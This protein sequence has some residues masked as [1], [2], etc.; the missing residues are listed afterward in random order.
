MSIIGTSRFNNLQ[1]RLSNILGNGTGDRGYGQALA[2]TAAIPGDIVLASDINKLYSDMLK[3][4]VHQ[5]GTTPTQIAE[6]DADLN[7]IA[8]EISNQVNNLGDLI[9][10]VDGSKKGIIA[11]ETLMTSLE[12]NRFSMDP[13]QAAEQVVVS[14]ARSRVWDSAIVHEF[15]ATFNNADHRRHFF[16]SGGEIRIKPSNT[17]PTSPKGSAWQIFLNNVGTIIFN[18]NGT[19]SSGIGIGT[20][21]GN[22]GLGSN[23]LKIFEAVSPGGINE[24]VNTAGNYYK[25]EARQVSSRQ[26]Q[27]R[28]TMDDVVADQITSPTQNINV[29][30]SGR[31]NAKSPG[32]VIQGYQISLVIDT[33]GSMTA[34]N[35]NKTRLQW[36]KEAANALIDSLIPPGN[37][38]NVQISIVTFSSVATVRSQFTTNVA[39]LKST[40]N[41]LTA[42]G[43]TSIHAGIDAAFNLFNYTQTGP[44]LVQNGSFEN[45]TGLLKTTFGFRAF[46]SLA[47]GWTTFE[48]TGPRSEID[49]HGDNRGGIVPVGKYWIDLAASPGDIR[50]GQSIPNLIN[51][52]KYT[53]RFKAARSEQDRFRVYWNGQIIANNILPPTQLTDYEFIVTAGSGNGQ[54]RFEFENINAGNSNIGVAIDDVRFFRIGQNINRQIIVFGDGIPVPSSGIQLSKDS[55]VRAVNGIVDSV[56]TIAIPGANVPL[57]QELAQLGN[58]IFSNFTS[59]QSLVNLINDLTTGSV[60]YVNIG[61]LDLIA[62]DG[63]QYNNVNFDLI[64]NFQFPVNWQLQEGNNIFRARATIASTGAIVN[65]TLNI[66][67][68]IPGAPIPAPPPAQTTSEI[69]WTN[70]NNN[71]QVQLPISVFVVSGLVKNDVSIYKASGTNLVID[72][73]TITNNK[74]LAE[75][76]EPAPVF[77]LIASS[78]SVV[79][80]NSFEVTLSTA[81]VN[82]GTVVPYTITGVTS[83]QISGMPLTGSF[84]INSGNATIQI[85]TVDD[86]ILNPPKTFTLAL[87]QDPSKFVNVIIEDSLATVSLPGEFTVD[88]TRGNVL[89]S[90]GQTIIE[91]WDISEIVAL[92]LLLWTAAE[93]VDII[94]DWGDGSIITY[95]NVIFNR[96]SH[97]Y[98]QNGIYTIKY[99]VLYTPR[100][101]GS[102]IPAA[103]TKKTFAG[104]R[105]ANG[106][107][108]NQLITGVTSFGNNIGLEKIKLANAF[109]L[110]SVPSVIPTTVY[111]IEG[112]FSFAENVIT[113]L[114]PGVYQANISPNYNIDGISQWNVSQVGDFTGLFL[115]NA[116]VNPAIENW[117][118]SNAVFLSRMFEG[119][120]SFDR[121]LNNWDTS[122]VTMMERMFE[123]AS[124]FNSPIAN[125][126]TS[127]VFSMAGMFKNASSF[128]S[129][130]A[131][132]PSQDYWNTINVT[133]MSSIFE[134]ASAFNQNIGNWNTAKVQ[135]MS[136]MFF[137][138]SSFNQNIGAWDTSSV[139][140]MAGMFRNALTFDQP[141]GNWDTS[142][143]INMNS[144]FSGS[145]VFDQNIGSWN[146]S[147]VANMGFMFN[148]A[149]EFNQPIN[150]WDTSKV[151]SMF[152]M[153]TSA[154]TFNQNIGGWDTSKVTDMTRMFQNAAAFNQDIG[155]WD[156][157]A[158]P[159]RDFMFGMFL[160]AD[161]FLQ[162][163]TCWD[164]SAISAEPGS[165][166]AGSPLGASQNQNLRP[167]WGVPVTEQLNN[168]TG[169]SCLK[170]TFSLT[171]DK[172]IIDR[173]ETVTITLN[174]TGPTDG[175]PFGYNISGVTSGEI[176]NTTLSGSLITANNTASFTITATD[177]FGPER[178]ISINLENGE[179]SIVITIRENDQNLV[180]EFEILSTDISAGSRTYSGIFGGITDAQTRLNGL[181]ID[182]GDGTVITYP[183]SS[184]TEGSASVSHT[185]AANPTPG[186]PRRYIATVIGRIRNFP[187]IT[188][189]I[190]RGVLEWGRGNNYN[191]QGGIIASGLG[192][193]LGGRSRFVKVPPYLPPTVTSLSGL[194]RGCQN[195]NDNNVVFWNTSNITDMSLL[196]A[197]ASS[198]NRDIS[199]WNTGNV[200]NMAFMFRGTSAFNQDIGGWNTSN[201]TDM[202]QM[203]QQAL[204]FN[205]SLNN[206]DVSKVTSTERMFFQAI[207]FN[208]P[209]SNWKTGNVTNMSSMFAFASSFNQPISYN[210]G[211]G[212]WDTSNVQSMSG[213]FDH[214]VSF[215]QNISNWRTENV[216]SM[217]SMFR[218]AE[219]FNRNLSSWNVFLI[220]GQPTGF[221]NGAL[222]WTLPRPVWGTTGS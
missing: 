191:P 88:T 45:V 41:S 53:L 165:F 144:L 62:P 121:N 34:R 54:N 46:G 169:S 170:N 206:W 14:S 216:T 150:N 134:G 113:N 18:Y 197:E 208:A 199:N 3:V 52:E 115:G 1:A 15:T 207:S 82:D 111:D 5:T 43:N 220:K 200:T 171:A 164:V 56:N 128:N 98:T 60:N 210:A 66:I 174:T 138:A 68:T 176:N 4:K 28:V 149:F 17:A 132:N 190:V 8:L 51:G 9:I 112:L 83:N 146:T 7:L 24:V 48:Q 42:S 194:F 87:S 155:G 142:K 65:S 135:N 125:W 179:A 114:P 120:T 178:V 204:V 97:K 89:A 64:G 173:G 209:I 47:G 180:L 13:S 186:T 23:Y 198:F 110:T 211:S 11:F 221:D 189:Q 22:S 126:N 159:N 50:I 77:N 73:P 222:N 21:I 16:N 185:Y 25:V 78:A 31:V 80:G 40:I 124:S 205:K 187:G 195:F 96:P 72:S 55:T 84:T 59:N 212:A 69:Q 108:I 188:G 75:S 122:K 158:I 38:F 92:D 192:G 156:V 218:Q 74:L 91:S 6:V 130:I 217:I 203:F 39:S 183:V 184:G 35:A 196:F 181:T 20:S 95:Q 105:N 117:N 57:M 137:N 26:I 63:T 167:L 99:Y 162:N 161:V 177:G 172:F 143:V 202:R 100:Q 76:D 201:V 61:Q 106:K 71:Q 109:N 127:N 157:S 148:D 58:G 36:V 107:F 19:N 133:N 139:T 104:I 102:I 152:S 27:F 10:D 116:N 67:G 160:Q 219:L 29:R 32:S 86:G 94:V 44:N 123:G 140:N 214:A 215:N 151:T 163:L 118:T 12:T 193:I 93:Q 175:T 154:A 166:A 136:N 147:N 131:F 90:N 129:P 37:P 141:I 49:L 153:F 70:F 101:S 103:I 119:A 81:N 85:S 213:M 168:R 2:S 79:E 30:P 145:T 182:W 33:S